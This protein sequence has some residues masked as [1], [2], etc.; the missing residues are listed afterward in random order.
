LLAPLRSFGP[1]VADMVQQMPYT[2]MQSMLDVAAPYGTLRS[3]WKSHFLRALPDEAIDTFVRHAEQCPSAR[4]FAILEH[5]HGVAGRPA[6]EATAFPIRKHPFDLVILSLWEDA[7]DDAAQTAWTR[8]FFEEMQPWSAAMVYVNA[9]SEDDGG[10]I[11]EAY[12]ANYRRLTEVKRKYDPDNRF[13][14]NQNIPPARTLAEPKLQHSVE[15]P[16]RS[17][18]ARAINPLL[19]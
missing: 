12:G 10:R 4:T 2:A 3:Y 7:R 14:R 1:P 5:S 11:A 13:R 15:S 18:E 19:P 16:L 8:T 9:F 17:G 6:P